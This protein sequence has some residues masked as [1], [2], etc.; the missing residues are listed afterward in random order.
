MIGF[1]DKDKCFLTFQVKGIFKK[2]CFIMGY[3]WG[4]LEGNHGF[5]DN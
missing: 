1:E 3:F 5:W 4:F 2:S